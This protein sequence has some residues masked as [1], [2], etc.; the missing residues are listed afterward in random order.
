MT[1]TTTTATHRIAVRDPQNA[2]VPLYYDQTRF[3]TAYAAFKLLQK[4]GRDDIAFWIE[5]RTPDGWKTLDGGR[6]S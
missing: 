1:T 6:L 3:E 5:E 4:Y 2:N